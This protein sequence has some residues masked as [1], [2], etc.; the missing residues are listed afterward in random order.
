MVVARLFEIDRS[1][2]CYVFVVQPFPLL[3]FDA[4]EEGLADGVPTVFHICGVGEGALSTFFSSSQRWFVRFFTSRCSWKVRGTFGLH[5]RT[6]FQGLHQFANLYRLVTV[7]HDEPSQLF[8]HLQSVSFLK[9]LHQNF[10]QDCHL[11]SC[12]FAKNLSTLVRMYHISCCGA[13]ARKTFASWRSVLSCLIKT[14][15][16]FLQSYW[17]PHAA[18]HRLHCLFPCFDKPHQLQSSSGYR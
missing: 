7:H 11:P 14:L 1:V 17:P 10:P 9:T 3:T 13:C 5:H 12:W 15:F 4:F 18:Y 6:R 16:G 8:R 2:Q